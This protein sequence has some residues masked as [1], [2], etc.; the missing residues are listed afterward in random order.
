M[1]HVT[2]RSAIKTATADG[3]NA[4]APKPKCRRVGSQRRLTPERALHIQRQI[5]KSR[6]EQLK[7]EFAL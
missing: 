7:L 2:V 4:L 3:L 5:C 6:P 1:G